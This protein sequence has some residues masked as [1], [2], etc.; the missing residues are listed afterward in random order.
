MKNVLN[1][2]D[3]TVTA[4]VISTAVDQLDE[5]IRSQSDIYGSDLHHETYNTSESFIYY[6]DAIAFLEAFGTFDAI[7]K[8][9]EYEKDN[10]G[11]IGTDISN[12]CKV[13]NML[14]YILG[15]ELLNECKT[16]YRYWDKKIGADELT[17][18][19]E[20]IESIQF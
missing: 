17:E 18:I 2:Y 11:E 4:L 10:F 19:K 14:L 12:P 1:H 16:V 3:E 13:A 6:S 7:E 9:A 5:M 8:V 15:E 20:E